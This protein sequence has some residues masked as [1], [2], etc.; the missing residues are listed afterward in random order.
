MSYAGFAWVVGNDPKSK[1]KKERTPNVWTDG[2]ILCP[3]IEGSFEIIDGGH[4]GSGAF[5]TLQKPLYILM[6]A[7]I[8]MVRH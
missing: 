4:N 6:L 5:Y 1:V 3:N 8:L 7:S 2:G